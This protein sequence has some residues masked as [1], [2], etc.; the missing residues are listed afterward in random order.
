[1]K[2]ITQGVNNAGNLLLVFSRREQVFSALTALS[3]FKL[4]DTRASPKVGYQVSTHWGY[5]N[6]AL[7]TVPLITGL[8]SIFR[9]N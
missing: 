3:T 6:E 1:M 8:V 2:Y 7:M 9:G 4:L 5:G